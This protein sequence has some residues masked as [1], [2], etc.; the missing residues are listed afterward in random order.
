MFVKHN[1]VCASS[2]TCE[3]FF[4]KNRT[5]LHLQE[6]VKNRKEELKKFLTWQWPQFFSQ[7][8]MIAWSVEQVFQISFSHEIAWNKNWEK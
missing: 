1:E 6:L 2:V 4:L 7:I 8:H 3:I 5:I